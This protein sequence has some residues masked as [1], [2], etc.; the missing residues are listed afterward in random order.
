MTAAEDLFEGPATGLPGRAPLNRGLYRQEADAPDTRHVAGYG[1]FVVFCSRHGADAAGLASD[2][3]RLLEFL[4]T[5]STELLADPQLCRA[6]EIFAG[7]TIVA[8]RADAHW[9]SFEGGGTE[10]GDHEM[11]L[12]VAG[13]M[14]RLQDA[15]AEQFA[16]S[17]TT[18]REW[19]QSDPEPLPGF[20]EHDGNRPRPVPLPADRPGY[21]RPEITEAVY[22]DA[23]GKPIVYGNRWGGEDAPADSYSVTSNTE[24]F[25]G[26]HK[27]ADALI[28]HLAS[29]YEVS[30][31][32]VTAE[33]E[34]R[35]R[36]QVNVVRAVRVEPGSPDAA[37][38]VF[39]FTDFPGVLL[40]SG[41]LHSTPYPSCGCDA[42]DETLDS[43]ATGLE[44]QVL[45]VAAGG[46]AE[47]YPL[48][49]HR[50]AEYQ[51]VQVDGSGWEG[52]SGEPSHDYTTDQ[53]AEAERT[54]STLPN[55]WQPWPLR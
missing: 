26:L 13:L 41:L 34:A 39:T 6:A 24:R 11:S 52:G 7:N 46:F 22:S 51:L 14:E 8:Q 12:V 27:V 47:R 35:M 1:P 9:R 49:R 48:G 54:L 44:Q 43:E 38:L 33:T 25:S 5:H 29:T 28:D 55:G 42:C 30:T 20:E 16:E 2:P 15:D 50:R 31:R 4:H 40:H 18:I 3:V 36:G 32:D 37:P 21:A 45:S 10:A 53:L 23:N 19:S 17:L